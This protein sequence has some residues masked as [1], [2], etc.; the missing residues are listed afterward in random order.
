MDKYEQVAVLCYRF[1]D[2]NTG[3]EYACRLFRTTFEKV[4]PKCTH[5]EIYAICPGEVDTEW[6][7]QVSTVY[8]QLDKNVRTLFV[9]YYS[10][11]A[12]IS[13]GGNIVLS[14]FENV[15]PGQAELY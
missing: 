11:H 4:A 5:S 10:G 15:P 7:Y 2:D 6:I 3:S 12:D 8:S 9:V 13:D 14:A 1:E